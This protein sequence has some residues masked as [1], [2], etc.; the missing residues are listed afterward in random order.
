MAKTASYTKKAID[1]YRKQHDFLNI[2]MDKGIKARLSAVGLSN[3]DI[4]ALIMAELEKR[5]A[6]TG[7]ASGDF[8]SV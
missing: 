4:S 2:T 6:I 5:E 7:T 3:K 8:E 1:D